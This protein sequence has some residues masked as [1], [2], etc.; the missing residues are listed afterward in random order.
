MKYFGDEKAKPQPK[1]ETGAS[2]Q[3]GLSEHKKF[4]ALD[5]RSADSDVEQARCTRK[6]NKV[7]GE[8]GYMFDGNSNEA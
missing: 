7:P 5:V 4:D 2:V 3:S 6:I 1:G 8:G